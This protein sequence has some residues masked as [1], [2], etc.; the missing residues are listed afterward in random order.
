MKPEISVVIPTYNREND[1]V[2]TVRTILGQ[3][4][5]NLELLVLD[6]SH[7][8]QPETLKALQEIEIKNRRF[9]YY[10]IRPASLPAARNFGLQAAT[11]PIVLFLDDDIKAGKDL[12]EQHLR[13]YKEH[14]DICAV[15]GRVMQAGFPVKNQI[16]EFNK[17][18]VSHGVFTSPKAGYT[19]AFAGGNHSVKV[20]DALAVGGYDTRY[21]RIA[22]REESD[23]ALRLSH[24]GKKIYYEPKAEIF[25]L[26]TVG[27]GLRHFT[28]LFDTI[29][30]YRNDLF[31]V[32][33]CVDANNIAGA[34][35]SKFMEYCHVRPLSKGLKRSSYFVIGFL[36]ALRRLWFGR[37]VIAREVS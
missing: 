16:L 33:H 4:Y 36:T 3:S 21:Y 28:D 26:N 7:S 22:F 34:L 2:N 30:F 23:L 37:Q 13:V 12:V 35:H 27:G 17:Y 32:L 25:H 1:L 9:R 11:A 5:K 6:Q 15:G 18:G 8:H 24:A 20:A 29:D 10:K 14:P 31:F 19:N